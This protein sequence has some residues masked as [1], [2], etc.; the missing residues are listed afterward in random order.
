MNFDDKLEE[1]FIDMTEPPSEKG[2]AVTTVRSGKH[3]YVTGVIPYASGRVQSPGRV[4]VEVRSD[5][6]KLAART[7][8]VMVLSHAMQEMGGTLNKIKRIIKMDAFVACGAEFKEHARII[9]GASE[10]FMQIF[11]PNGKHARSIAGATS[12]PKNACVELSVVF[13]VK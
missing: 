4:G 8:A 5:A 1:L 13:E 6:G 9:D 11:G 12:L 7:A 3:L 10:L 2:A